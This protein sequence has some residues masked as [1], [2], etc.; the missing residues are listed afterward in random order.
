MLPPARNKRGLV[1]VGGKLLKFIFGTP[2][3][4]DFIAIDDKLNSLNEA[5]VEIIH[6]FKDQ[7]TVQDWVDK[8]TN[9][10]FEDRRSNT[11][12]LETC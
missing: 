7:E 11:C 9:S 5:K 12:Y 8:K 1:Y 3:S 2:D 6:H 4:D 10:N